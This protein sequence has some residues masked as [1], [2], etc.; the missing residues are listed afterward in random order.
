MLIVRLA[1]NFTSGELDPLLRG[2]SD[3]AQYQNGLER[4][5]NVMVQPQ[6]GLRRRDGLRFIADFTGFTAF[7]LIPFEFSTT[8]SYLLVFVDGRVYVYK[9]GVRQTNINGSG[10]DYITATGLTAAM[11]DELDFAQAVD[12]LILCHEDLETKRLVRN[13]DT[14]WTWE[15]LPLVNIPKYAFNF[16]TNEPTFTITP[17]AISGNIT[18]TASSAT[19]DTGTAQAGSS[20]TI[21]LK[22]STSY[23][24]DD[25]PNG[26][27]V[28]L[29]S[30][31]GAG[32][33]RHIED[34]VAATKVATVYPEWTTPPDATTG[35]KVAAFAETAVGEF[36]QV[37]NGFG[38]ARYVEY[39]SD[40]EMKA[41]TV[42]PF[43]DTSGIVSGDWES[44][45]GYEPTWSNTRGWPRS[46][47]FHQ[48][49]LY[50]GG[51][52]QRTNTIWGSRVINYFD[53]DTGTALDDDSVEATIATN[54]FNAIVQVESQADLRIFT[55]GG[56]FIIAN[57]EGS[58]ITPSTFL[59]RPQTRLGVKAGVPIEDLNGASIFV[60]RNGQ[61]LNAF[62]FT[63]RTASYQITPISVLSSHL[64]KD[65]VDLAIRRGT[66]TDET[67][68]LYVVNGE[69]GSMTVYSI[70]SSQGVI[71]ASEFTTGIGEGDEF[72]AV[73]AELD[74]V[75][76]IVKRT[77]N[78][79]TK[80]YLERFDRD[81]LLDSSLYATT[82]SLIG[83][84]QV[85]HL[86]NT[87]IWVRA[88]GLVQ[89]QR[90]VP[91]SSPYTVSLDPAADE[92]YEVGIDIA[93]EVKT[94]PQEP[95]L[96]TG[97][98]L[99]VQ[100]RI[101]QVDALVKDSQHMNIN[102]YLIAFQI[103]GTPVLNNPIT[104]F[105]GRK[106][107]HGLLG[108]TDEGQITVSQSY[109]LKLNLIAMEYRL[110]LGN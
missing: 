5:K 98:S 43:F 55:T 7:K 33:T 62:Q 78:A 8:D 32:Q 58:P 65:P 13:S 34:Y 76:V 46:A 107:I 31:T 104:E 16:L 42:V 4:A 10:N 9:A 25:Q 88:D 3:L 101:M 72:I 48:N 47:T 85:D 108:Y 64:I 12:T 96:P 95:N 86:P 87:Q 21:T 61:S 71:A 2:R 60:Q 103:I 75:Y 82:G 27:F 23:G 59:V 36:A 50:F 18:L 99:G 45:H 93:V 35:Y 22:S 28:V 39:V 17:S 73:A 100:K 79:T 14:S 66:S 15:D 69:D 74:Q 40:T 105:T 90:T 102:G 38:R 63:D 44:E 77:I 19:T 54:Q 80:Y 91:A 20:D 24:T 68:T 110:S 37:K 30:G 53:F 49:R 83:S 1:T 106:T 67:D 6:G 81:A 11:L 94:M 70:L 41:V 57:S 89:A 56:E 26:M 29:T 109:P 84:A 92:D 97:S 52:K 51:S